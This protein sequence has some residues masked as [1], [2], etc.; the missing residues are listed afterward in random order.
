MYNPCLFKTVKNFVRSAFIVAEGILFSLMVICGWSVSAAAQ[1]NACTNLFST[2]NQEMSQQERYLKRVAAADAGTI[3]LGKG[4]TLYIEVLKPENFEAPF[5]IFMPGSNRSFF[6]RENR[7]SELARDGSGILVM[8]FSTQPNSISQLPS[9]EM[10]SFLKTQPTLRSL[11]LEAEA[12]VTRMK[13]EGYKNI[14]PV[15]LS[16]SGALSPELN[17][18]AL[19][20]E[21]APMTSMAAARPDLAN[22]LQMARVANLWN[23][24]FAPAWNRAV[25]DKAYRETWSKQADTMIEQ[26]KLPASRRADFIEGYVSM[27]RAAENS[28]WQNFR[29][30]EAKSGGEF[31]PPAPSAGSR[32]F[33]ILGGKEDPGL[34]KNQLETFRQLA[35]KDARTS[36]VMI[37]ESGHVVPAMQPISFR[38]ALTRARE[39]PSSPGPHIYVIEGDTNN[40]SPK[41]VPVIHE[42]HGTDAL[43]QVGT[44]IAGLK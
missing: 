10:P 17:P 23:P 27:S 9:G 40:L 11:A 2:E 19:I 20:I 16:Y 8:N 44:W 28:S 34:L 5:Y 41:Q 42:L 3:D 15:S 43:E 14:I 35:T 1:S 22:A 29:F 32:R 39:M 37:R 31:A 33:F 36:L 24:F 21:T 30:Q 18:H 38:W 7:M 13:A 6:L 4:Q 26:F 12:V 25:L